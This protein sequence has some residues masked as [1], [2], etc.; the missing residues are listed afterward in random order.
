MGRGEDPAGEAGR[1]RP[2][3]GLPRELR[4]RDGSVVEVRP[5]EP[6]DAPTVKRSFD[7]LSAE[8]RYR[9]FFTPMPELNDRLLRYLTDVDPHDH[10]AVGA[11]IVGALGLVAGVAGLAA[12]RRRTA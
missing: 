8:S 6:S 1:A 4:L 11:L 3:T 2:L 12:G 5:I 10:E 7:R 9:R